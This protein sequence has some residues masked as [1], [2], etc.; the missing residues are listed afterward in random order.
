MKEKKFL[1]ST[2]FLQKNTFLPDVY[3][4]TLYEAFPVLQNFTRRWKFQQFPLAKH[5]MMRLKICPVHNY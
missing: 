4:T 5:L 1:K 2:L 3:N